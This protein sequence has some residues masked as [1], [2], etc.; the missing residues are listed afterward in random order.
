MLP[1]GHRWE[2]GGRSFVVL[3]GAPS[4][5]RLRL[6]EGCT[7]WPTEVITEK[8]VAA[9]IAGGHAEIMLT[10]DNPAPPY[11]TEPVADVMVHNPNDW[12]DSILAYA[13]E[14][15][16]KVTRATSGCPTSTPSPTRLRREKLGGQG[17]DPR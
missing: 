6:T 15:I 2:M 12:P 8:H 14:G 16:D 13:E 5:N 11:C 7:W 10:H 4:V 1:R 9:T 3:G 17:V